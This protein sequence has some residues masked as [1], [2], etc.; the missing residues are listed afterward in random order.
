MAAKSVTFT[1]LCG[2]E[3]EVFIHGDVVK[4]HLYLVLVFILV[5]LGG[6]MAV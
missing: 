6:A 4:A 5:C 2:S 1:A 3:G